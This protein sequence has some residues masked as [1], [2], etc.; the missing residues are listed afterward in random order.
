MYIMYPS[1]T[2]YVCTGCSLDLMRVVTRFRAIGFDALYTNGTKIDG[3]T[4]SIID[5]GTPLILGDRKT[6]Q[7][8]Y[9]QIPGSAVIGSGLCGSTKILG[10]LS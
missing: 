2:D 7:V 9:N 10:Q 3:I 4:S 8:L 5:T 6:V 1:L